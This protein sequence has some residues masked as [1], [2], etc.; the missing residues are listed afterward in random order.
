MPNIVQYMTTHGVPELSLVFFL[1]LPVAATIITFARQMLGVKAFG[2]YI[3]LIVTFAF[4]ATGIKYGVFIFLITVIVGTILR[5]I[6]KKTR[7][8][9]LPRMALSLIMITACIYILFIAAIYLDRTGFVKVSVFPVLILITLSEKFIATQIRRSNRMAIILTSETLILS[10]ICYYVITWQVV[11]S[12]ALSYPLVVIGAA[13]LIN[14][15]L[16]RWTGLRL[17]EYLRFK[18]VSEHIKLPKG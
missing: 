3:P 17:T 10:L 14:I 18:E 9:Y 7:L 12:F 15:L 1:M 13:I 2:I 8:L 6:L 4:L 16:G 11:Q 5:F